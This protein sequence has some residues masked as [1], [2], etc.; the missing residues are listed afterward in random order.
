MRCNMRIRVVR[1]CQN[2]SCKK[3]FFVLLTDVNRGRGKFCTRTC[4]GI[5]RRGENNSFY[6]KKHT[7]KT[8]EVISRKTKER[9]SIPE[10]RLHL[11]NKTKKQWEN[12]D[13]RELKS[14][15]AKEQWS[16]PENRANL[17]EILI[18]LRSDPKFR[19]EQSI[20]SKRQMSNPLIR[21]KISGENSPH[22]KGGITSE[23]ERIRHSD[24][25]RIFRKTV[26]ERDSYICQKCKAVGNDLECHHQYNFAEVPTLRLE[27]SNGITFCKDCHDEFH[28]IFGRK[29]NN[30]N[31]VIKFLMEVKRN[32]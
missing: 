7:T 4:M 28:H 8:K 31:Q 21:A 27:V 26:Y 20:R 24:E 29:N 30:P 32:G 2:E 25:Y 3:E 18:E 13:F 6:G 23:N 19:T 10:T 1:I 14:V 15:Q 5:A 12:S 17:S 11:S 16:K 22:W 9:M